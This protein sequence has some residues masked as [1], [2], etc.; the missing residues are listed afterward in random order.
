MENCKKAYKKACNIFAINT[1]PN[2]ID[3]VMFVYK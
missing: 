3:N 1:W 2:N